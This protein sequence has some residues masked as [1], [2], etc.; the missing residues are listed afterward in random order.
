M[1]ILDSIYLKDFF[2][3]CNQRG[4]LNQAFIVKAKVV[5]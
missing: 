4:F 2:Y 5:K 3:L 1:L